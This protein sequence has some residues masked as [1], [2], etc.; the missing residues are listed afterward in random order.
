MMRHQSLLVLA[1]S[2]VCP[3]ALIAQPPKTIEFNRDIRPILSDHCYTCHGPA[4]STRKEN[5]RVDTKEG[6][7]TVI[8]PGK[9][10]ESL[11]YQRIT[12]IDVSERM[13]PAKTGK[14]LSDQQIDLIRRWIE[15]GAPWQEHWAFLAPQRPETPTVKNAAWVRNPIDAFILARL[16]KEG[17]TPIAAAQKKQKSAF[18]KPT[19][20]R[21]GN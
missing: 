9:T 17:L 10:K 11:L 3:A 5:L 6:A 13:P 16:E 4:K 2:L 15:Q 1:V 21:G 18:K 19:T 14:K 7:M 12:S 20:R 8:A